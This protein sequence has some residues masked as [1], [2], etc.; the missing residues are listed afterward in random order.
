MIYG[1]GVGITP[2]GTVRGRTM[3]QDK[4]RFAARANACGFRLALLVFPLACHIGC[5]LVAA[6]AAPAASQKSGDTVRATPDQMHQLS[7]AEVATYPFRVQKF[8]IGQIAYNEDTSTAVLTPFSGRVT[9]LIAKIGDAVKRGDPLF[10]I[11]SPE[12]VQPQND[13]VAAI[14]TL[15]KARS[16]LALAQIVER[17]ARDLYTGK[18]GPLKELQSAEAGL[19]AAENDMRSA[20]TALEAGR[21]RL[22]I[23]GW[24]DAQVTALQEK[25]A[26]VRSTPIH[27]PIDGTVVAR[28]VGPGQYVR[29]DSN[30]SL[31]SIANLSTM[32]LKA[33]VPETDIRYVRVGQEIEV[34]VPALP[35]RSYKARIV[36]VG[37]A[38]DA[39]TRRVVVRSEVPN[40]DGTLKSEM[41]ATFKITAGPDETSPSVPI[42]SVIRE[43]DLATVW[44]QVEPMLFHRR[45]VKLGIEQDGRV[46]IRDGL[47]AGE[48][49]VAHGAIFVDN[50]WRQ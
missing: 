47:K 40:G 6:A 44:V 24:P 49:V 41:F 22:R 9:R 42:E 17:R 1:S 11:D 38:S 50:E 45:A 3:Q 23:L 33:Y 26:I 48:Q 28:K 37:S 46:Q 4:G 34:K 16:Q 12:I 35:D 2:P 36:H 10:D 31:Y 7:I 8:A 13:F 19:V 21:N 39:A 5:G 29:N 30:E 18:A 14:A 15:N 43:R 32:W 20:A 25:G 27:A